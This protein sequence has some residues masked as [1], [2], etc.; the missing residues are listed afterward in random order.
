MKS[1]GDEQDWE[2]FNLFSITRAS[3]STLSVIP[4]QMYQVSSKW[5]WFCQVSFCQLYMW[6][7]VHKKIKVEE[8]FLL[9]INH[10]STPAYSTFNHVFIY[11]HSSS[12]VV[13]A[14]WRINMWLIHF[15]KKL[16]FTFKFFVRLPTQLNVTH[17]QT[18]NPHFQ[19]ESGPF[20]WCHLSELWILPKI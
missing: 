5:L 6:M 1:Y 12:S 18:R 13:Y 20:L 2:I 9:Y 17:G 8:T 15:N 14:I 19:Y 10:L 16:C 11:E 7:D 4:L 3:T